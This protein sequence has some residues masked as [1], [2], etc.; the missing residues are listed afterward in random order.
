MRRPDALGR[1]IARPAAVL[2][3]VIGLFL[4]GLMGTI[5]WAMLPSLLRP[6]VEVDGSSFTG[7][8]GA[9]AHGARPVRLLLVFGLTATAN[10]IYMMV[11]RKQSWAFI[12]VTLALAA[13][14][15]PCRLRLHVVGGQMI[16]ARAPA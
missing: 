5:S 1:G 16:T 8:P 10:G 13:A 6:G 9:G 2:L 7:T 14:D 15:R 4:L 3:V 12:V 11:T